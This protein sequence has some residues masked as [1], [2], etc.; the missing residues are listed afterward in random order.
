MQEFTF[1]VQYF[2]E[3]A[4][5]SQSKAGLLRNKA[6]LLRNKRH[7]KRKP[8]LLRLYDPIQRKRCDF[9]ERSNLRK[10]KEK[11]TKQEIQARFLRPFRA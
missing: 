11:V 3:Q 5:K 4:C 7:L 10:I 6:G 1:F 2:H 8:I 9:L